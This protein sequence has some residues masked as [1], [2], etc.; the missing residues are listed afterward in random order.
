MNPTAASWRRDRHGRGGHGLPGAFDDS[1]P[2]VWGRNLMTRRQAWQW[3]GHPPPTPTDVDF[4]L[5]ASDITRQGTLRF[6]SGDGFLAEAGEVP[7]LIEL[8][9]LLGA[10][11]AIVQGE[12]GSADEVAE[13]L[14]TGSGSLGGARPK[15]SVI[16]GDAVLLVRRFDRRGYER[17][18]YLSAQSLIA[19]R[20]RPRP[21]RLEALTRVRCEPGPESECTASHQRRSNSGAFCL[22]PFFRCWSAALPWTGP[23]P[24]TCRRSRRAS[25]L[26]DGGSPSGRPPA[27]THRGRW[28]L[29]P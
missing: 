27:G 21:G 29:H 26:V 18:A 28:P 3:E 15:A 24:R 7:K 4:L 22:T 6:S 10:A 1:S 2:E 5:G 25:A 23:G 13:L 9:R 11:S 19:P 8:E 17:I 20:A 16:D 14:A 12:A